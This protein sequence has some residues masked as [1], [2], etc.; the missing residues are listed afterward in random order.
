[1]ADSAFHLA[2]FNVSRLLAPLDDPLLVEFVAFLAPVN[3]FAERSPGF[4]WRLT[5]PE[6]QASSYLPSPFADPMMITSLTVRTGTEP[7]RAFAYQTMH[8]YFLQSRQRWFSRMDSQPLVLWWVPAG[9]IPTLEEARAR[10][11][12]LQAD[13]PTPSAFTFHTRIRPGR[14]PAANEGNGR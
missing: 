3:A 11:G 13:D 9:T 4:V 5:A 1:M 10:L 12:L 14:H 7:L 8:R 6:S 2:Q